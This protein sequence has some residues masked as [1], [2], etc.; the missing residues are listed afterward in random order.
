MRRLTTVG[1]RA[2]RGLRPGALAA[3]G[4]IALGIAAAPAAGRMTIVYDYADAVQGLLRAGLSSP[5]YPAPDDGLYQQAPVRQVLNLDRMAGKVSGGAGSSATPTIRGMSPAQIAATLAGANDALRLSGGV[6]VEDYD[7]PPIPARPWSQA[8]W[9]AGR[10]VCGRRSSRG[11]PTGAFPRGDAR[12]LHLVL[13]ATP[14][15]GE[16]QSVQWRRARTRSPT[17]PR[18][19]TSSA[20]RVSSGP[21][22]VPARRRR[23]P[24]WPGPR[25]PACR[26][27]EPPLTARGADAVRA[28]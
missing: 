14:P 10:G 26:G 28:A 8:Q 2:R 20:S 19:R 6:W 27:S 16:D 12:R 18:T 23:R 1:L 13:T 4:A 11:A 22:S 3:V 24:T 21:F 5:P 9:G 7:G 25:S 17:R 15:F